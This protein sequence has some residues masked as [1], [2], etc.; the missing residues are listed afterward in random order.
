MIR[1][2]HN[3]KVDHT[4]EYLHQAI[5]QTSV[6]G[7][8]TVEVKRNPERPARQAKLT[9]KFTTLD[10]Q[11][12][13]HHI[14]KKQLEPVKL[15]VVLAS[16]ENPPDCVKAISWLLLTTMPINDFD[17]AVQC[18]KWYTSRW[19]IERYHYV[20]KSGC[21][22]EKLQLETAKRINMALATYSIVAWRLLWLTYEAR[23][24]PDIPCTN[25]L[26]TH[27]WQSLCAT[28]NRNPIPPQKP[29]SLKEAVYMIAKLG[30]FLCRKGDGN[31]GVKTIWRGLRRLH[32]IAQTWKLIKFKT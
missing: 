20:L 13:L 28:I 30:G 19:L 10:I 11:V 7:T 29:P 12:P 4:A 31:P 25:V 15:Q 14:A 9:L 5:N 2:T 16:E 22:I 6:C 8:V 26:E 32:D 1:G 17:S 21:G 18:V 27:E 24:N 3:R 23:F